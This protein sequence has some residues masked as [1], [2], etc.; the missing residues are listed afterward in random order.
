MKSLLR[1]VPLCSACVLGISI[2]APVLAGNTDWQH[3]MIQEYGKVQAMPNAVL[4]PDPGRQYKVI[5]NVTKLMTSPDQ[6]NPGLDRVARLV[7]LFALA[8]VPPE[9]LEIAAV[10]H[11]GATSASLDDSHY[12]KKYQTDNPNIKLIKA[13]KRA[14]VNVY[15]CGQALA[16]NEFESRW[17]SGEVAVALSAM[18]VLADYQ[19]KGYALVE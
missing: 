14:G 10:L 2:S 15:V 16:H 17:V 8:K 12:R 1:F 3:P 9:K 13:L 19:L 5:V 11:G 4:Q 7:N 6:V 18:I